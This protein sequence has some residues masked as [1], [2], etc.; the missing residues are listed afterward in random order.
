MESIRL[1]FQIVGLFAGAAKM[2]GIATSTPESLVLEFRLTDT[3]I[4][5]WTGGVTLRAIPWAELEEAQ[6]GPG[7]FSPWLLLTARSLAVFDRL[8]G[9]SPGQLRLKVPWR[10]RRKLRALTSEINLLLSYMEADRY[11]QHLPNNAG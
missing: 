6:C 8:P 4:G 9:P 3:L 10:H 2:E 7:F 1:P 5:A 11:R